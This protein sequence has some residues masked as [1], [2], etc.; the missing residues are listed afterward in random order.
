[1]VDAS[2]GRGV[3]VGDHNRQT[4]YFTAPDLGALSPH[5]AAAKVKELSL[6]DAAVAL[7]RI[8]PADAA[9]IVKA[10]LAEDDELAVSL[11]VHMHRGR[12]ADIVAA[13]PGAPG[14]LARLPSA[15]AAISAL[16]TAA[17]GKPVG[18]IMHTGLSPRRR[19]AW[20]Q[21][22]ERGT[23]YYVDRVVVVSGEIREYHDG[24]GWLGLPVGPASGVGSPHGTTGTYQR[25]ES[26]RAYPAES[27]RLDPEDDFGA[28]VYASPHGTYSSSGEV[29]LHHYRRGGAGGALGFPTSDEAEGRQSFEGGVI[30]LTERGPVTVSGAVAEL[31]SGDGDVVRRL[32]Q[33][34]A[35]A[36]PLG[37]GAEDRVQAF[38]HGL[39]T[40]RD[41]VAEAW[42]RPKRGV[43]RVAVGGGPGGSTGYVLSPDGRR[44]AAS[45]GQS[46]AVYDTFDGSQVMTLTS[47]S[48]RVGA[49][50]AFDHDGRFLAS[51]S[52]DG[53]LT[54]WD[55]SAGDQAGVPLIGRGRV[56]KP[57]FSRAG[58]LAFVRSVTVHLT[59]PA[60][61]ASR[62]ELISVGD[63]VTSLAFSPDGQMLAIG[64]ANGQIQ[65]ASASDPGPWLPEAPVALEFSPDGRRLAA[66]GPDG[67]ALGEFGGHRPERRLGAVGSVTALRFSPDGQILAV[68]TQDGTVQFVDPGTGDRV[69]DPVE[70][71]GGA[72]RGLAFGP[73]DSLVALVR[74]ADASGHDKAGRAVIYWLTPP[75]P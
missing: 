23:I 53:A 48:G 34:V 1:M 17:L 24:H 18:E 61:G 26:R 67:V 52:N 60:T 8:P 50:L 22:F 46:V 19:T 29:G 72:V 68:A 35:D 58:V 7:A 25:F 40:V 54:V 6:D 51:G 2:H 55:S 65:F 33:P 31:L 49:Q 30:Q 41:D 64:L 45:N 44:A 59:D 75:A 43:L 47:E 21:E 38:Q 11:L 12:A 3:Q 69:G 56:S 13:V 57:V 16:D 74:P 27:S 4:N 39:V 66:G 70:D 63:A 20:R 15:W 71:L 9:E 42:L 62:G 5:R 36:Q 10:L 32:G 73:D 28:T 37:T 14:W